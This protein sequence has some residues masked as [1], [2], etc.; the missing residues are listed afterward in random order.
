MF[1]ADIAA[2]FDEM[3]QSALMERVRAR[4]GDK[5]V[6]ALIKAFLR[7]GIMSGDGTVGNL[8]PARLRVAYSRRCWP[9][10]LSRCWMRIFVRNGMPMG[11]LS[12]EM[13]TA[14]VAG[15]PIGSSAIPT[16]S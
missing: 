14:N 16:I 1:E 8:I 4:I 13:P 7:A 10:S 5:R 12:G 6:L 11:H 15:L 2:C 9:T 3:A